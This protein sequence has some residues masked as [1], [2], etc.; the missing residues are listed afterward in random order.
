MKGIYRNNHKKGNVK[1]T[2]GDQI[3][4]IILYVLL[5]AFAVSTILPFLY[6][7]AGSFATQKEIIERTFFII[8]KQVS[9]NAYRYILE[10]GEVF[11]GLR[12]SVFITVAG[13]VIDMA[14]TTT[15]AYPLARKNFMGRNLI[16]DLVIVTMVFSGGIIP[17][18][19]VI[20]ALHMLNTYWSLLLPGAISAYNMVIVKNFFERIPKELEEAATIDGC[21]DLKIF[22]KVVLPL[23]K[24]VLASISL[25]YAVGH[26]N[27]YFAPMMYI[28]DSEKEVIQIV[29]RRVVLLANGVATDG[30]LLDYGMLG[31]PPD[32]AVKMAV[33]VVSTMPI[34]LVYPFIQK[35]FTK[36]VMIGAVKG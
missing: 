19:L 1:R 9:F 14:F 13:T 32:K 7:L 16:L 4:Q 8:P 35:Y 18:F 10:N 11:R 24:P 29:L 21:N 31:T 36:G 20:K 34:L 30:S 23:S 25:F 33:T 3:V 6:V 26:W 2:I 17:T 22:L 15:F 12:N 27:D 5:G 28:S